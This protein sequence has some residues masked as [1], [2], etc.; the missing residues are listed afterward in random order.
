M[1]TVLSS[2]ETQWA[3]RAIRFRQHVDVKHSDQGEETENMSST[4][5]KSG[6]NKLKRGGKQTS[7]IDSVRNRT[8]REE[9]NV[10]KSNMNDLRDLSN[11]RA[12]QNFTL[13]MNVP[14]SVPSAGTSEAPLEIGEIEYIDDMDTRALHDFVKEIESTVSRYFKSGKNSAYQSVTEVV[15]RCIRSASK[16]YGEKEANE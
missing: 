5:E 2:F 7:I 11:E 8:V 9:K 6:S 14:A 16:L 4:T 15:H 1:E 10:R 12:S 3:K 13:R